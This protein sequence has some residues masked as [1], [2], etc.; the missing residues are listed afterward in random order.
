[1]FSFLH[2][3]DKIKLDPEKLNYR[4]LVIFIVPI[5][6]FSLYLS[7]YN[8]SILTTES[9][10]QLHQIATGNFNNGQPFF[11]TFIEMILLKLFGTTTSIAF[12]QILVFSTIWM[13]ICKY[14]RDDSDENSNI[15]TLQFILTLIIS[16]IPINAVYAVTLW[17]EILFSYSLLFLCFLIKVM[18]D[19]NGQIGLKFAI[20]MSLTIAITSQLSSNGLFI[21]IISLIV[22]SLYLYK[23]D[24][25]NQMFLKIPVAAIIFILLI[26]S[27]SMAYNVEDVQNS[28]TFINTA[29]K[30]AE[31]DLKLDL[32]DADK[33]KINEL[34]NES[35]IKTA[36]KPSYPN[37]IASIANKEVFD[38]DSESYINMARGYSLSNPFAFLKYSLKSSA[39]VWDITRNPEWIGETYYIYEDGSHLEN[40]RDKYFTSINQTPKESFEKVSSPNLGQEK[41][42]GVNS[43]V[44]TFKD[45]PILDT[46]FNSPALY[47][48]LA[49]ILLIAIQFI[50]KSKEMYLV[51]VPNLLNIIGVFLATPIQENRLLY[52]NLLVFYLLIII[53]MSIWFKS[54]KKALPI[55][56]DVKKAK[57]QDSS[58]HIYNPNEVTYENEPD[59]N[60]DVFENIEYLID[61]L[62][63]E[64]INAELDEPI[65]TE[66]SQENSESPELE[67]SELI[68]EILKEI[69]MEKNKD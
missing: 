30:L 51:Y 10:A 64:E 47:M 37:S 42:Y 3:L 13:I 50:T 55:I 44:T 18:I 63:L 12:F 2:K 48:Y 65:Y 56:L 6:I 43:Y 20:I 66:P 33:T 1:M 25:T 8:P 62:T 61:D 38:N 7:A 46:L 28:Q 16:L 69:E 58:E 23:K 40:A 14:H 54:D 68:D 29:H 67:S 36:Y 5:L 35:Q 57:K 21:A 45:N 39:I 34:M 27:L 4:D 59:L 19:K 26:S 52:A 41:Y 32:N 9:F 53:F 22:T 24:K 60:D 49:I 15:Y 17:K 31:Y 11:H